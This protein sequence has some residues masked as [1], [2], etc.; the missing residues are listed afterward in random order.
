MVFDAATY[1]NG[2][3]MHGGS[4]ELTPQESAAVWAEIRRRMPQDEPES[5]VTTCEKV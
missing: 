1:L 3:S 5:E 2:L 4:K